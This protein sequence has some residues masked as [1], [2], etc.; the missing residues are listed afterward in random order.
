MSLKS[1]KK[2]STPRSRGPQPVW[3]PA[4]Q[5]LWVP[6]DDQTLTQYLLKRLAD[7]G[8]H[9]T[10]AGYDMLVSLNPNKQ[11]TAVGK[12]AAAGTFRQL[13]QKVQADHVETQSVLVVGDSG[14]GKTTAFDA[15]L[16]ATQA[17]PAFTEWYNAAQMLL[18]AFGNASMVRNANSSRFVNVL[19]LE[20]AQGGS[21]GIL[22]GTFLPTLLEKSR[23]TQRNAGEGNFHVLRYLSSLVS[24]EER[25]R[26]HLDEPVAEEGKPLLDADAFWSAMEHFGLGRGSKEGGE[27]LRLLAAVP[28]LS[29]LSFISGAEN[30]DPAV[31]KGGSLEECAELLG[32]TVAALQLCLCQ[33]RIMAGG[34]RSIHEANLTVPLAE[35][36]RDV[37]C[38]EVYEA[39]FWW[40]VDRI[41]KRSP[42]AV[43]GSTPVKTVY[44]VDAFGFE[45]ISATENKVRAREREAAA[46]G[47]W[48]EGLTYLPAWLLLYVCAQ[49]EQ[50]CVNYIND[51]VCGRYYRREVLLREEEAYRAEGM[52]WEFNTSRIPDSELSLDLVGRK[53]TG[54]LAL[55][56]EQSRLGAIGSDA[57][58]LC[59]T[60]GIWGKT[61]HPC[62]SKPRFDEDS[63]YVVKHFVQPVTYTVLDFVDRNSEGVHK[64]YSNLRALLETS[65]LDGVLLPA[66]ELPETRKLGD[67]NMGERV[68]TQTQALQAVLDQV[69]RHHFVLCLRSSS[70]PADGKLDTTLIDRQVS[71][72][73]GMMALAC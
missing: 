1:P 65:T 54:L 34:H 39:T 52:A 9:T 62:Y 46:A 73:W 53:N 40:L 63:G 8:R 36:C 43:D 71:E 19:R 22:H 70:S 28:N 68:V 55:L 3:F 6:A 58:Y 23:I 38:K 51:L 61:G 31:V 29:R 15:F 42:T 24:E 21:G 14:S 32:V 59:E 26:L 11:T 17:P 33:R 66:L 4:E 50:L 13:W 48:G 35:M 47:R 64:T 10:F 56:D 20:V 18:Q 16:S 69:D 72:R 41:N 5:D 67:R 57:G 45:N 60:R 49:V 2:S 7:D 44:A 37:L 27:I 12:E 30:T 25:R